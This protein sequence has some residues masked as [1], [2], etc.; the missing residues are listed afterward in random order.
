MHVDRPTAGITL[1]DYQG[2]SIVNLMASLGRA[3][4]TRKPSRYAPVATLDP[5]VFGT[6]GSILLLVIDGLG[7]RYLRETA[8]SGTLTKHLAGSLTSVFPSTTATAI[9]AFMTGLAPQQHAVTGWSMYFDDIATVGAVLPFRARPNDEPLANHG[10]RA[11]TFFDHQAFFDQLPCKSFIVSPSR[12]VDSEFSVAHSGTAQ[13]CGYGS[14]AEFFDTIQFCLRGRDERKFVYAY[15]PELDSIAHQHGIASR[16]TVELLDRLDNG[17]GRLLSSLTGLDVT[18]VVT[19][20]HG[21]VDAPQSELIELDDHPLLAATLSQPLCGERRAAYCYVKPDKTDAFVDYVRN[22]LDQHVSL[23]ES[24]TLID[25]GWF[26]LGEPHPKLAPRVGDYTLVMKNR[27]TIKDWMP[28]ER[29]HS[30]IGVHGGVS[31]DEMIVP[32]VVAQP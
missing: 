23:W 24:Q 17:I 12:I 14:L 9:T 15:Y 21:F 26:G 11:K 6:S 18:V 5:A 16:N 30:I 19:A 32:L 22:E 28:G 29:H 13:R 7:Y 27:A 1:P 2:G 31:E 10:L 8:P 25:A 4:G 3:M 20:D